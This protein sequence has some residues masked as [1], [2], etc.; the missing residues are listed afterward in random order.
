M[1]TYCFMCQ[2]YRCYYDAEWCDLGLTQIQFRKG[3]ADECQGWILRK[4]DET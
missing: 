4:E 1:K 2:N 3:A